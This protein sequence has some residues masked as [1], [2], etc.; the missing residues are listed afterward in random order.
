MKT[1]QFSESFNKSIK[2]SFLALLFLF[3]INNAFAEDIELTG[4]I[5]QLGS[6][7]LVVQG[8]TFYVDQNT[9]LR[10]P[11]GNTVPFSFFQ[12]NDFVQVKGNIMGNGNYLATRVKWEDNPNNPNEIELTGYVTSKG[13]NSFDIDGTT[14]L[15]DANTLYRGRHGNPFSFDMIQLGMLLE[16]KAVLQG[17]NLLAIRVK[18]EDDH[19]NQH[20]NEL[21]IKGFI[22]SK[23]SISLTVGQWEFFVNSQ[24]VILNTNNVQIPF[25]QL[26][27][28]DFVEIK[29]FRQ[30]DSSFLAVRIKLEDTPE[31]QIEV[32]AQIDSINGNDITVGGILFNT[33]SATIFL[34]HN[35]MPTTIS[36]FTVGMLVEVKGHKKSD[37]S[38]Y[39]TRVKMEDFINNEVE[40]KGTISELDNSFITVSGVTFEVDNLT[41]VFDHLNNPISYSSLQLG[42]LVEIKGIRINSASIRATRIKLENTKDIEIFGRITAINSDN[43]EING[44]TVFVN[45]NTIILNHA[46]QPISFS[47]LSVDNFVEVKMIRMPDSTF[48]AVKIKIE[49]SRNFSRTIGLVGFVNGNSIQ[50]PSGTYDINNQTVAIDLNYNFI[51]VSQI[52]NGQPVI[53]WSATD[54]SSNKT[55]LQ[56][57]L[58]VSLPNNVNNTPIALDS[59]VLEQ[60]YPNPFNP[61]TTIKFSIPENG[62]VVLKVF[63]SLGEEVKTIINSNMDKGSHTVH[64]DAIGLSSGLYFYRLESGNQVLTRKMLLLK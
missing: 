58:L 8:Y 44:L 46:N 59:Y 15:V 4:N 61:S 41:Q 24:T 37:G 47:D 6:D 55:A 1:K 9:E 23:T 51:N 63:N 62:L 16:V 20:S 3:T 12:L 2:A 48:L 56:I 45:T 52:T 11:N 21:E 33:D 42:Q 14:F 29:A 57:R 53:V 10:G 25:S 31:N 18:T 19:N 49:D 13:T 26:N 50:L 35:R 17:S 27:V 64:F 43:I 28:G 38:Y 22:D 36:F 7:W 5:A 54:A 32:K 40:V 39:A 60:N 34:D 30:A